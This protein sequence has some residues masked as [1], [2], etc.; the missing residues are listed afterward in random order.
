MQN[1]GLFG[2][3]QTPTQQTFVLNVCQLCVSFRFLDT[4]HKPWNVIG[5]QVTAGI[6]AEFRLVPEILLSRSYLGMTSLLMSLL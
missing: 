4:G 5:T 2:Q 3:W 6:P 1:L